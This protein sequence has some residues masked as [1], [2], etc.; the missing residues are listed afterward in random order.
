[1]FDRP[2]TLLQLFQQRNER[3]VNQDDRIL[4]MVND[5]VDLLREEPGIYRVTDS[6]LPRN[7]LPGFQVPKRIPGQRG[8]AIS[9]LHS[10]PLQILQSCC[11][12]TST[13]GPPHEIG[14]RDV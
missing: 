2:K 7:C 6:P 4:R 11:S 10:Q 8:Y 9:K 12:E 13:H 1:M 3:Q 14:D 5:V